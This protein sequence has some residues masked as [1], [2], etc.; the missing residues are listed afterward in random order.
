MYNNY[1]AGKKSTCYPL[2]VYALYATDVNS[3]DSST[4]AITVLQVTPVD[5]EHSTDSS[6]LSSET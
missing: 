3:R 2:S 6:K 5:S 1:Q 4:T